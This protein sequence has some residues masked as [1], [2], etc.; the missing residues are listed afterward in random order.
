MAFRNLSSQELRRVCTN[1]V[2][3]VS[4]FTL[5]TCKELVDQ[6]RLQRLVIEKN[7]KLLIVDSVAAVARQS[8]RQWHTAG[9]GSS[10]SVV[11]EVHRGAF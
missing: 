7:V 2:A 1:A 9:R 8:T 11:A 4:V 3:R 10:T 6:L 5:T